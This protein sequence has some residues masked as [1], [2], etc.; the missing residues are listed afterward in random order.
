MK[1]L[2]IGIAVL[3]LLFAMGIFLSCATKKIYAPIA[4]Q[5]DSAAESA[6]SGDTE[7]GKIQALDAREK[8]HRWKNA[9]TTVADHTPMEEIDHL[10]REMEIYAATGEVP[11]FAACCAQLAAMIR[12]MGEAHRLNL[13]NLL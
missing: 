10:F 13:W 9:T 1:R 6:L 3:S 5:L 4:A 7:G 11:H 2:F 12:D 8:W